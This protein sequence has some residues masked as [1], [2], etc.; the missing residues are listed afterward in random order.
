[1]TL[2]PLR[3]VIVL[4]AALLVSSTAGTI[5][6][7]DPSADD[8]MRQGL[9]AYQRGAFEQALGAWKQA[10]QLYEKDGKLM[11]QSRALVQAAHASQA[12]GQVNQALQQL[13]VAYGI[14]QKLQ[15]RAWTINVLDS[16]GRGYLAARQPDAATQHLTQALEMTTAQ[17]SPRTIAAIH[18]NLGL[19]H[20]AQRRMPDA[21]ASFTTAAEKAS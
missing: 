8:L 20:V 14:A 15:D 12:I 19:A 5:A 18:N 11:D 17:D 9:Q 6:A 7:K 16:L 21:L 10:A 4:V 3:I 1:M 13:E 2:K